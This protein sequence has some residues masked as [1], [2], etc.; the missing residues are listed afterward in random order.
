MGDRPSSHHSSESLYPFNQKKALVFVFVDFLGCFFL[1][2]RFHQSRG[3]RNKQK[4]AAYP[5]RVT[6]A[7]IARFAFPRG[8]TA[9]VAAAYHDCGNDKN[10]S[11]CA[12]IEWKVKREFP[13]PLVSGYS[14]AALLA[15]IFAIPFG[16]RMLIHRDSGRWRNFG[17][18]FYSAHLELFLGNGCLGK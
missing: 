1:S 2:H 3:T 18:A 12:Y 5:D 17:Q 15:I 6:D 11:R 9:I 10:T 13:T 8:T 16:M 7:L 14:A 4:S